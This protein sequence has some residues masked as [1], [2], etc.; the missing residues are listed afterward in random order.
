MTMA[1]PNAMNAIGPLVGGALLEHF[2]WGS[3]FLI[4]VPVM[5]LVIPLVITLMFFFTMGS[6][7]ASPA[8]LTKSVSVDPQLV[9]S[10]SGLYGCSQMVVG[11]ACTALVGLGRDPALSAGCVLLGAAVCAQGAFWIALLGERGARR[12]LAVAS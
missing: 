3:V 7:I 12:K 2:W 11:A 6:G 4:N 8:A 5:L 10:A 9:G 1:P